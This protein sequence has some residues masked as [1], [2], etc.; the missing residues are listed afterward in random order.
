VPKGSAINQN[1]IDYYKKLIDELIAND[2]EPVVTIFHWDLPQWLQ[3]FG[4]PTNAIFVDYFVAYADVLF[5]AFG[6]KVKR[7]ITINEPFNY[8]LSSYG[9]GMWPPA[10][11]SSGVGEYLCGHNVL[12]AHAQT[13]HLY[14]E[15]YYAKFKGQVGISLESPFLIPKDETVTA[16]DL[17]RAISFRF[18]WF[19]DPIF[20]ENGGY[21]K[22]MVKIIEERSKVEG[23]PFSRLP[24]MSNELKMK[25]RGSA[26]FLGLNYYTSALIEID[27]SEVN[28]AKVP[29]WSSD[30]G[31]IQTYDPTWKEAATFWFHSFPEGL[32]NLLKYIKK[33]YNN[34]PIIITENGW[35]DDGKLLDDD[36]IEYL[37]SHLKETLKAIKIDGCNVVAHSI[38][39]LID[40][41]EWDSGYSVH[42]GIFSVNFT[43]PN[44]ERIPKKSAHH[45]KNILQRRSL[46]LL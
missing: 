1:G 39:S 33:T 36:R 45:L 19:A 14:R 6:D 4:G 25:I 24:E 20:S 7:W 21:P 34:P 35:S 26:D 9:I 3:N 8:C 15:K 16:E 42:F 29:A 41:F 17:N 18:G 37:N 2:I 13:Y 40:N 30:S 32:R 10:T 28:T 43:S 27:H 31:L 23:Q 12:I 22:V 11:N 38:W 5:K 46:E 44:L